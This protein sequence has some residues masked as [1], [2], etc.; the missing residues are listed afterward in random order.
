M[1]AEGGYTGP[2]FHLTGVSVTFYKF[3]SLVWRYSIFMLS[4]IYNFFLLSSW[5]DYPFI[6][7]FSNWANPFV[8]WAWG[9]AWRGEGGSRRRER[10]YKKAGENLSGGKVRISSW[11]SRL[12]K[13]SCTG[14]Y[15]IAHSGKIYLFFFFCVHVNFFSTIGEDSRPKS[16]LSAVWHPNPYIKRF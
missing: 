3:L 4:Q 14:G 11:S 9:W 5:L 10:G 1:G 7:P 6:S 2:K 16:L 13:I 12:L 8:P 15:P